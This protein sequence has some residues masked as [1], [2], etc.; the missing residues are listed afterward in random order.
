[1]NVTSNPLTLDVQNVS[2]FLELF[3]RNCHS[4][5]LYSEN[6]F[7]KLHAKLITKANKIL[8]KVS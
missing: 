4:T 7:K 2:F 8:L 5:T 6:N 3:I 1:M